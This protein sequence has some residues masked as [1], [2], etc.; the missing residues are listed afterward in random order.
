MATGKDGPGGHV[1]VVGSTMID[2]VA[3]TQRV[4]EA[5]ETLVGDRFQ[6]G[7]GGKGANQAVMAALAGARVAMVN[8]VGE[9]DRE[10]VV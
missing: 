8:A 6:M 7:F 1:L 10:S 2:L 9:E 4:P 5:G 3:Y